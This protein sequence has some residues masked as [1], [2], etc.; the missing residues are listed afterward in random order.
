VS[1]TLVF[2]LPA[3]QPMLADVLATGGD[4]LAPGSCAFGRFAGGELHAHLQDAVRGRSCALLG[5][6]APPDEQLLSTL[7]A[8]DTVRREGARSLVAALPYLGYARQ[9]R[10]G[11]GHS[12]GAGWCGRLLRAVGVERLLTLDVHSPRAAAALELPLQSISPAEL[13]AGALHR[14]Q[15]HGQLTVVAPDEGALARCEAVRRA[16]GIA[17]PV[18]LLRKRRDARGVRHGELVGEVSPRVALVDDILDTGGTLVSACAALRRVGVTEVVV[19]VTHALFV[20]E[21]WRELPA[22]GVRRI[23]ATD[24]SPLTVT[25]AGELVQVLRCGSLLGSAL[26]RAEAA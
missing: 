10:A 20:G 17:A 1:A 26:A 11:D 12:A 5:S 25:R 8:G 21:R 22:L 16:A 7:L 15:E 14:E 2:P 19:L 6:L 4:A 18:A 9:D 24:S 3:Y 13:F 23:Y